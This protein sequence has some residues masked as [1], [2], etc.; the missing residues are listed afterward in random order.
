MIDK[1]TLEQ[2]IN[3]ISE[4]KLSQKDYEKIYEKFKKLLEQKKIE[5][6]I[7][8]ISDTPTIQNEEDF[9]RIMEI[10]SDKAKITDLQDL[11]K[12]IIKN[13]DLVDFI[14]DLFLEKLI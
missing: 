12:K 8:N 6:I 3:L 11:L 2:S 14:Q 1:K 13:E 5:N 10:I 7:N 4:L 9:Q